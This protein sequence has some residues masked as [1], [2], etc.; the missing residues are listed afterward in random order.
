MPMAMDERVLE[1]GCAYGW[2]AGVEGVSLFFFLGGSRQGRL[3]SCA[4]V[5]RPGWLGTWH[6]WWLGVYENALF[7]SEFQM[8]LGLWGCFEGCVVQLII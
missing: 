8:V 7:I 2:R 5:P 6:A 1:W 3:L 4:L